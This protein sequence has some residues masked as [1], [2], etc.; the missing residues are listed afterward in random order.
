MAIIS[1][2][3]IQVRR[4]L[5]Q[6]LPQLASGELGWAIDTRQLYVGNGSTAEGA[7][8][9]GNTE[10][11]TQFSNVF[12]IDN[13]YTFKGNSAG[14]IVQ[15]GPTTLNPIARSLQ[16][17]FDDVANVRD[18]GA[19]GDGL[20][21]DTAA[22]NRA[23]TQLYNSTQVAGNFRS[24]RTLYFPAGTYNISGDVLRLVPYLRIQG[25]GRN[26]T[27]IQQT[28]S[29]QTCCVTIADSLGLTG[30]SMGTT[31]GIL[32]TGI[33]VNDIRFSVTNDQNVFLL[34]SLRG[35]VF[36]RVAFAGAQTNPVSIGTG[37]ASVVLKSSAQFTQ[38]IVFDNC[39]FSGSFLGITCDDD[40]RSVSIDGSYFDKLYQGVKLGEF[41]PVSKYPK[42][43]K[44]SHSTFNSVAANGIRTFPNA[45][46]IVS[47]EN[48]Y[49]DVGNGFLGTGSPIY[50]VIMYRSDDN[51]SFG[52]TF[53]RPDSDAAAQPRVDF[54][55]QQCIAALPHV[56][57]KI[58][59]KIE[60]AGRSVSM[61]DN[62]VTPIAIV[63]IPS[64][65]FTS[66]VLLEYSIVRGP[67]IRTGFLKIVQFG[68]QVT[69]TDDFV[70]LDGS[71][72]GIT[73]T[74]KNVGG[75][76]E[77]DYVST[78]IGI[79]AVFTYSMRYYSNII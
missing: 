27:V 57:F 39:E 52:D 15:T 43:F 50:P 18:F 12:D 37:N 45:T 64:Q 13:T 73:L 11:L 26:N 61:N 3:R 75:I 20:A 66:G 55:N 1:I 44:V 63:T 16:D 78:N 32:P 76:N 68:T 10:I 62:Q 23:I 14:F 33:E 77:V 41:S 58:G 38:G 42:A 25:D 48:Y 8:I 74:V 30:A 17:K 34:D 24:R 31:G 56:G 59:S 9:L 67:S 2:S 49:N 70:E 5:K 28:D 36:R 51:F 79:P 40:V 29:G 22:I 65:T 47:T 6:D 54:T 71:P 72:S 35:S 19:I 4:G 21:D 60:G 7:P 53:E 46:G 69:Y